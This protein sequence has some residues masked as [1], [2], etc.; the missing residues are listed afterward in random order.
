MSV[1]NRRRTR[2]P[3]RLVGARLAGAI[4][5]VAAATVASA[6]AED[7]RSALPADPPAR[8]GAISA[9]PLIQTLEARPPG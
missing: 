1:A 2:A 7:F 8:F 3:A 4:A 6:F 9:S 5:A